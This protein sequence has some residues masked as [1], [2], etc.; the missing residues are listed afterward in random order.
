VRA[1]ICRSV[2]VS[3]L[4]IHGQDYFVTLQKDTDAF[5]FPAISPSRLLG[6]GQRVRTFDVQFPVANEASTLTRAMLS[7]YE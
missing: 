1:V 6:S 5:P 7:L 4:C 3:V 2:V